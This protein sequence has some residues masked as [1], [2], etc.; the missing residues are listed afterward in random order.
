ME[1][2]ENH[3]SSWQRDIHEL[4]P[5]S[6]L[7]KRK[8]GVFALLVVIFAKIE[9]IIGGPEIFTLKHIYLTWYKTI[10]H[11]VP[12]IDI[13]QYTDILGLAKKIA[14]FLDLK[15]VFS[16]LHSPSLKNVYESYL[17][18]FH[19]NFDP[20]HHCNFFKTCPYPVKI[21]QEFTIIF[22]KSRL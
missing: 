6:P 16:L 9:S 4:S 18:L 2:L 20:H 14:D 11:V 5:T 7:W 12:F 3:L 22:R 15:K 17:S 13:C 21:L 19:P 10:R 8:H 1:S